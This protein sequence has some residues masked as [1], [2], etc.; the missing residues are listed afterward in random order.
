MSKRWRP[1]D[2]KVWTEAE[3]LELSELF[4][5]AHAYLAGTGRYMRYDRKIWASRK[6]SELH[7][8]VSSTAAYKQL[9]REEAW[10]YV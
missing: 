10:R 9:C 4:H 5:L 6:Y 3:T 2:R 8:E 7:P 1:Q